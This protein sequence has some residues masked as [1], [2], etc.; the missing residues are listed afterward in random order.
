[1]R[2][3][4][5]KWVGLGV[6]LATLGA[7]APMPQ[8]FN[9]EAAANIKTVVIAQRPNQTEYGVRVVSNPSFNAGLIGGLIEDAAS[10]SRTQRLAPLIK[11]EEMRV[12]ERFSAK[13]Q[14]KLTAMGYA[15]KIVV[16]PNL[17]GSDPELL[18]RVKLQAQA[19][20]V[21]VVPMYAQYGAIGLASQHLPWVSV[22][23]RLLDGTTA[24]TLYASTVNYGFTVY[25]TDPS[26]LP[27]AP[28]YRFADIEA[29][30]ADPA[31][32]AE[33]LLAGLDLLVARVA[34]DLKRN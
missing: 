1:V 26:T 30:V 20:A 6:L 14:E 9:R 25:P 2:N 22:S 15:T 10:L 16:L 5:F 31:K 32:A 11:P 28:Q 23:A 4:L 3:Q 34:G 13:L 27:A 19:D 18:A 17:A 24:A 12:Q 8:A 7:C 21:L 29:L 33:G